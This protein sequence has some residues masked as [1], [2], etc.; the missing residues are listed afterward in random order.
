MDIPVLN[1]KDLLMTVAQFVDLGHH[2]VVNGNHAPAVQKK[3]PAA[4]G[5]AEMG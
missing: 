4:K 5:R 1:D 2:V 3:S